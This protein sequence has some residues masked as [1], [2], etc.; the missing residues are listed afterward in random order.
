MQFFGD[1]QGMMRDLSKNP[2]PAIPNALSEPKEGVSCFLSLI[3]V[4]QFYLFLP[5][6]FLCDMRPIFRVT[7]LVCLCCF[8][9]VN[10]FSPLQNNSAES[11]AAEPL[12]MTANGDVSS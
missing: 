6:S 8:I 9:S 2:S 4:L 7:E 5:W 1:L 10:C 11:G 3:S 12:A